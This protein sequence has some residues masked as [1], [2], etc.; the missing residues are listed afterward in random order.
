M[1][2]AQRDTAQGFNNTAQG[3]EQSERTLGE[4]SEIQQPT[5]TGLHTNGGRRDVRRNRDVEPFQ[6]F[7]GI[8]D[9]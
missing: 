6:G 3:R 7:L 8:G 5:L 1:P 2:T 4:R 9:R